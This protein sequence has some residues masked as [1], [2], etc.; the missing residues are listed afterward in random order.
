MTHRLRTTGVECSG[1]IFFC[2]KNV[3]TRG[4]DIEEG[5]SQ[6]GIHVNNLPNGGNS[7]SKILM[8]MVLIELAK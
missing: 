5:M 6:T 8:E 1:N 4:P 3:F 2:K 7:N